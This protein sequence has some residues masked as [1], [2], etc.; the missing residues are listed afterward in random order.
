M[1]NLLEVEGT[2]RSRIRKLLLSFGAV[3]GAYYVQVNS[4]EP[5]TWPVMALSAV[6]VLAFVSADTLDKALQSG[7]LGKLMGD[8]K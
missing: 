6:V 1:L 5:V 8:K 4:G 3:G 7:A 2:H